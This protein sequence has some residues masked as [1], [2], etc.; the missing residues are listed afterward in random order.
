MRPERNIGL[1]GHQ[2]KV[3]VCVSI[4]YELISD[5]LIVESR[6]G[7]KGSHALALW[8]MRTSNKIIELSCI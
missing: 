5:I 3:C 8:N 4:I 6:G 2:E 7:R 1:I